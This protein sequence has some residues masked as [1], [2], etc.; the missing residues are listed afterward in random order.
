MSLL[1]C[2]LPCLHQYSAAAEPKKKRP[3][4]LSEA[5]LKLQEHEQ[6]KRKWMAAMEEADA[7][8][9]LATT[10]VVDLTLEAASPA[11][12]EASKE[13]G[14]GGAKEPTTNVS[15]EEDGEVEEVFV[16]DRA[17]CS[18]ALKGD[19]KPGVASATS[20]Q[21]EDDGLFVLDRTGTIVEGSSEKEKNGESASGSNDKE[22]K[23]EKV[24]GESARQSFAESDIDS[25]DKLDGLNNTRQPA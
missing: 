10:E 6:R 14:K 2:L 12:E 15:D 11:S 22:K 1:N 20:E 4:T 18:V 7:H 24:S 8:N 17:G 25:V 21:G 23:P 5:E 19:S 3:R 9:D 16:L 13:T